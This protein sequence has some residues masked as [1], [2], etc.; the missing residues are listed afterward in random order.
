MSVLVS[1]AVWERSHAS[2]NN[3][4]VLLCLADHVNDRKAKE[5]ERWLAWPSQARLVARCNCSDRAIRRAL[6]QL[7]AAGEIIDTGEF[8]GHGIKVYEITLPEEGTPDAFVQGS[9]TDESNP[10]RERPGGWTH[11]SRGVDESGRTLDESVLPGGRNR[12]TEPEGKPFFEPEGKSVTEHVSPAF[13]T[14]VFPPSGLVQQN[15]NGNSPPA[16]ELAYLDSEA[17]PFSPPSLK[18]Q[19]VEAAEREEREELLAGLEADL[20]RKP[21]DPYTKAAAENLRREL[22]ESEAPA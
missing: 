3:L 21:D 2:A 14:D 4:A 10:G 18:Q 19:H 17:V 13:A 22:A 15:S 5:G 8:V 9:G 1:K 7:E 20:E 16:G 6:S 11:S 12:P